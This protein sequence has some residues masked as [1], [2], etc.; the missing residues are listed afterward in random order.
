MF[1]T[2]A[3]D[4]SV[5]A[6]ILA[7]D[8]WSNYIYLILIALGGLGTLANKVIERFG[9]KKGAEDQSPVDKP[10]RKYPPLVTKSNRPRSTPQPLPRPEPRPTIARPLQAPRPAPEPVARPVARPTPSRAPVP[11][12]P[13][14]R[15]QQT[16]RPISPPSHKHA[17]HED[18]PSELAEHVAHR[19]A[20]KKKEAATRPKEAPSQRIERASL[21]ETTETP[22]WE[23]ATQH[24]IQGLGSPE[25]LRR[26]ILLR[27]I[28]G[29]P[30]ALREDDPWSA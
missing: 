4:P 18:L 2:F 23:P 8:D 26:A 24:V 17:A 9:G 28:L 13:R 29:P 22:R 11:T 16:A 12:P 3:N 5:S 27:E 21:S 10:A 14:R 30:V 25:E 15:R 20:V 19:A 6:A 1:E 7:V